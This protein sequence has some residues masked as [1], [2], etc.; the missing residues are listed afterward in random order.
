MT[1]PRV[2]RF[3]LFVGLPIVI[4]LVAA[5]F[6]MFLPVAVYEGFHN[7]SF[8]LHN[9]CWESIFGIGFYAASWYCHL[10]SHAYVMDR[11]V[12]LIGMLLWPLVAIIIIFLV[13][14]RVIR[15]SQRTRLIWAG[16]FLLSLFI[17]VGHDAANYLALRGAPLFWNYSAIWY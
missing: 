1:S 17:C 14:R 6:G 2:K 7:D 8:E 4:A 9:V 5:F 13:S 12:G 3:A 16:A 15:A 11:T 10:L